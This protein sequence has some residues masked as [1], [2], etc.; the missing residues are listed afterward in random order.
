MIKENIS[1][2]EVVTLLNEMLSLD[3][4]ATAALLANR[5]PCNSDLVNHPTIQVDT[6][7][8][9]YFVGLLG[10]IN[11]LFGVNEDNQGAI[12]YVFEDDYNSGGRK[13]VRFQKM[14]YD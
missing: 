10:V 8:G 12:G 5:V 9:V 14:K 2:D 1:I 4:G 3:I 11:G 7:H 13:L 6:Q